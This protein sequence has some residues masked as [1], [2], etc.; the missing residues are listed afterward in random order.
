MIYYNPCLLVRF[1]MYVLTCYRKHSGKKI[2]PIYANI[3]FQEELNFIDLLN[4][5]RKKI[6]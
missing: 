6:F 4:Q 5:G 1:A 2:N 3:S